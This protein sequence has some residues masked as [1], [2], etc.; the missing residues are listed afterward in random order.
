MNALAHATRA[1]LTIGRD[2][3][4]LSAC[5]NVKLLGKGLQHAHGD[6][7]HLDDWLV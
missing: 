1:K 4:R 5:D 2:T 3:V 7:F 6:V